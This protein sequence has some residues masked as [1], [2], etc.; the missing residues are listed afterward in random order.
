MVQNIDLGSE[1]TDD[2]ESMSG[3]PKPLTPGK[4]STTGASVGLTVV[5]KSRSNEK[6]EMMIARFD[7]MVLSDKAGERGYNFNC[8]YPYFWWTFVP[9][10]IK[11][12]KYEFHVWTCH[13]E[14]LGPKLST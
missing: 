9:T 2:N 8:P 5:A 12:L 4:V 6:E 3:K 1:D 10:S 7:K 11:Y 13:E 14:D